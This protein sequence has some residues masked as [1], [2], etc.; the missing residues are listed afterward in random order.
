V[1]NTLLPDYAIK[2][3]AAEAEVLP[4][5]AGIQQALGLIVRPPP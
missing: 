3:P 5:A 1:T 2:P 4:V